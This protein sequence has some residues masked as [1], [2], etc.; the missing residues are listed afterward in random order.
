MFFAKKI[1]NNFEQGVLC[2][3][4]IKTKKIKLGTKLVVE[5]NQYAFICVGKNVLD[6]F[7]EGEFELGGGCLPKVFKAC[8]LNKPRKHKNSKDVYYLKHFNAS[9]IIL[10]LQE[11]CG[12]TFETSNFLLFNEFCDVKLKING[13]FNFQIVDK[14]LFSE[15]VAKYRKGNDYIFKKLK[16]FVAKKIRYEFHKEEIPVAE[17][18]SKNSEFLYELIEKK[19][20]KKT[21]KIGIKISKFSINN[22]IIN[23]RSSKIVNQLIEEGKIVLRYQSLNNK[24][25]EELNVRS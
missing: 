15:F 8:G 10:N 25:V 7:S 1:Q 23:A 4:K 5:K 6:D 13:T 20:T 3:Q 18:L 9:V 2:Q 24:T 21:D 16:S 17:F 19:L 22:T 14:K 12:L 11:Y